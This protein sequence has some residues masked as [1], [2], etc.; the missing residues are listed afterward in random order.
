MRY[1][2]NNLGKMPANNSHDD[3]IVEAIDSLWAYER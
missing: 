2:R 1:F 3:L